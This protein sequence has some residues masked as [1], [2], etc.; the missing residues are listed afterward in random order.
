MKVLK[1]ILCLCFSLILPITARPLSARADEGRKYA[2]AT[3]R[4]VYLCEEM[5]PNSDCFAIPYS[6]CVEIKK[7]YDDWYFVSYARDEGIYAS[8]NG[9]CK[10]DD[11]VKVDEPP[12]N[13]YLYYPLEVIL[14]SATQADSSLPDL[15]TVVTVPFYG[16][17]YRGAAAY[18]CVLY[19][20]EFG[21]IEGEIDD[22]ETNELPTVSTFSPSAPPEDKESNAKLIV[23]LVIIAIAAVAV[24]VLIATGR[25][26]K[27]R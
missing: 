11:L 20:G 14:H 26:K 27:I 13:E 6:Y 2:V 19:N 3:S 25:R 4:Y 10:K 24:V 15:Q 8:I 22:Y 18:K 12:Q 21:Y 7:E 16:N 9:Y 23:A 1:A 17:Y 5:D